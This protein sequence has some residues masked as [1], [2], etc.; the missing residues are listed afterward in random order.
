MRIANEAKLNAIMAKSNNVDLLAH[1]DPSRLSK[2]EQR[3]E[4]VQDYV[5][6]DPSPW[7]LPPERPS[8]GRVPGDGDESGASV[9]WASMGKCEGRNKDFIRARA[10]GWAV[11]SVPAIFNF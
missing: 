7:R 11:V 9:R 3:T 5:Q 1:Q 4:A 6:H 8:L 2:Q 10:R